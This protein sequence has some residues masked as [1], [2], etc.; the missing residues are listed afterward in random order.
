MKPRSDSKL[1]NL[2]EEEQELIIEWLRSPKTDT[3]AGGLKYARE[4]CK[5]SALNLD[6]SH[7]A[8]SEFWAYWDLQQ[9]FSR[10]DLAAT[11]A[12]ENMRA[13]DPANAQKAEEFGNFV[14]TTNSVRDGDPQTFVA[15][16]RLKL[17]QKSAEKKAKI[18]ERKLSLADRRV[19]V[20]E[21]KL[22]SLKGT[23]EDG[24][25]SDEQRVQRMKQVFGLA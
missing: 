14:F 13:F 1:K 5:S 3:C 19:K 12:E 15:M 22:D 9:Q 20:M 10:A 4:M 2:S 25:L 7:R 8:L 16:Q 17:D 23:L 18:E 11:F 24:K 6:V 21:R